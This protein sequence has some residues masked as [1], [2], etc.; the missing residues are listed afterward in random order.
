M[1]GRPRA[2]CEHA[3]E[4]EPDNAPDKMGAASQGGPP[5][6]APPPDPPPPPEKKKK[7]RH[8]HTHTHRNTLTHTLGRRG[9]VA[10]SRMLR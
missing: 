9:C 5:G 2:P 10:R 6:L 4:G 8:T 7:G 1:R 3:G